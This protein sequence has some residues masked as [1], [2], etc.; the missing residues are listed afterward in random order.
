[1][2]MKWSALLPVLAI[3]LTT[4][5]FDNAPSFSDIPAIEFS[6]FCFRNAKKS[7]DADTLILSL[8]FRDGDGDLG[9]S[10]SDQ[11][12]SQYP[13][14]EKSYF[15]KFDKDDLAVQYNYLPSQWKNN[16][17]YRKDG[18]VIENLKFWRALTDVIIQ[19]PPPL[20]PQP[21]APQP[22]S[23]D[24]TR[25]ARVY[26]LSYAERRKDPRYDTLPS[27]V[28]PFS[29][30]KWEIIRDQSNIEVIDTLYR[31]YNPAHY[32]IQVDF[33]T[34]NFDGSF[35][36]FDWDKVQVYPNCTPSG[37]NGRFP[38]L[39]KDLSVKSP[40]E[41]NF[42][43]NIVSF[44]YKV[45]FSIKTLKLKIRVTDRALKQSNELE[46]PEFTLQ[47]ITCN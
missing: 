18:I 1:M 37:F 45:S 15:F 20:A 34:K 30:N 22:P 35:T 25:W 41:G 36:K 42:T 33:F 17:S 44:I 7:G 11:V 46:T 47:S 5:C 26:P 6:S 21:P 40:L 13:Y 14:H 16:V 2:R 43:Y 8:K 19:I 12:D 28:P 3:L 27:F 4:S 24:L 10:A 39:S 38:I 29:C 9:L 23:I 32:N 31:V